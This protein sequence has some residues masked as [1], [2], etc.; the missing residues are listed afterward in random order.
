LWRQ[1]LPGPDGGPYV[2]GHRDITTALLSLKEI[3]MPVDA[4]LVLIHAFPLDSSMWGPQVMAFRHDLPVLAPDMPGFG[5]TMDAGEVMSMEAS[6]DY[7]AYNMRHA[8]MTKAVVVGLSMGGYIALA[9]AKK[10]PDMMQGLVLANTRSG[11]DDD[12]AKDRR[13]ALADRLR[14]EGM[15]FL[16]ESPPPLLSDS[17]D[18]AM[19]D[20]VKRTIR[21]QL[22]E[23]VAAA[24]LGMGARPDLTEDLKNIRV[25]TLVITSTG[26][27]LIPPEA[28]KPMAEQIPNAQLEVIEGA[29]HLSNIEATEEFNRILREFLVKCDVDLWSGG[30]APSGEGRG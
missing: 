10:Y 19:W 4:G 8:E 25:P 13:K 5:G 21:G 15:G 16:A 28:T 27:K 3:P 7:V 9:F 17:A 26:D 12:A 22:P 30:T 20:R 29:G 11:A 23:A 14:A 2:D 24:S 18:D 1:S 6:A